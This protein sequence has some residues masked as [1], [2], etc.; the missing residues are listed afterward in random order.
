MKKFKTDKNIRKYVEAATNRFT[1]DVELWYRDEKGRKFKERIEGYCYTD[2]YFYITKDDYSKLNKEKGLIKS[3]ENNEID[4]LKLTS[5][6]FFEIEDNDKWVKV[7]ISNGNINEKYSKGKDDRLKFK[8]FLENR[9]IRIYEGDLQP[10]KR[11]CIDNDI[12]V[13]NNF[14]VLFFDIETDDRGHGILVGRDTILSIAGYD[15]D[16]KSYFWYKKH[17]Q[18]DDEDF[19]IKFMEDIRFKFDVLVGWNSDVFDKPYIIRRFQEHEINIWEFKKNIAHID[20][21]QIFI[22]RFSNNPELT[23]WK[24]DF[25]AYYFLGEK[26]IEVEKGNGKIYEL[27]LKDFEK[28]KK[29][30]LRD[31][32][33]LYELDNKLGVIQQ[34]LLECQITGCF[35]SKFSVSELL[36]TY[37]LRSTRDKNLHFPSIEY[38]DLSARCP[39]CNY[40]YIFEGDE[41]PFEHFC[42][43]CNTKFNP[44]NKHNDVA[45]AYVIEPATGRYDNVFVFDYKSLYPTIIDSWNIGPDSFIENEDYV[46]LEKYDMVGNECIKSANGQF[47]WKNKP[48]IFKIAIKELLSLRRKFKNKMLLC[49]PGTREYEILNAKQRATK[50]LSNSLYG[51]LAYPRGRFY[52]KEIAESITLGGQWLIKTTKKWFEEKGYHVLYG[53][54]VTGNTPV[55]IKQSEKVRL[56]YISELLST[57][58]NEG[59]LYCDTGKNKVETLSYNFK[60]DKYEWKDLLRVIKHKVSKQIKRIHQA[61]GCIEP[62]SDHGFYNSKRELTT[63][64]KFK[65]GERLNSENTFLGGIFEHRFTNLLKEINYKNQIIKVDENLGYVLGAY[66][67]EGSITSNTK[68][69]NITSTPI[70]VSIRNDVEYR[71]KVLNA[72]IKAFGEV[73]SHLKRLRV[74][75]SSKYYDFIKDS[76]GM[77]SH[78]KTI[79]KW[80]YETNIDFVK[81]LLFGYLRGDGY[82]KD[83]IEYGLVKGCFS[84]KSKILTAGIASLIL[85]LFPNSYYRFKYRHSK[86][87]YSFY[88]RPIENLDE[89]RPTRKLRMYDLDETDVYDLEVADN[90][91]F[92]DA[93]GNIVLHNTDSI[94]TLI[95]L[96]DKEKIPKLLEELKLFY[97]ESLKKN[98]NIDNHTIDLEYEKHF[99]RFIL[100]QKKRYAGHIIEQDDVTIDKILIKGL[101][102]VKRDTIPLG[103][104]WQKELLD[105]LINKNYN[106]GYYIKWVED[107]MKLFF[108]G[109][110][111]IS[112]IIITK[113]LSKNPKSYKV[114]AIHVEIA[115]E[116]KRR[117]FEYYI[118][119]RVPYIVTSDK[120]IEASHPSW[121]EKG[122]ASVI[123][124]WDKQ[125]FAI[126]Q[127]ILEAVF[128]EYDWSQYSSKIK[129]K[130]QKKIEQYKRWLKDPKKM[131]TFKSKEKT[132]AKI[133]ECKVISDEQREELLK[134]FKLKKFQ[135]I[136]SGELS[137]KPKIK[138][139]KLKIKNK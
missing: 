121:Y 21:M 34:I 32:W 29:Y 110:Y 76:C 118:G 74:T 103:R 71:D 88:W 108:G 129:N 16:G 115:E 112:D 66:L 125:I 18:S 116:L 82:Q 104:K 44:E 65:D 62:T 94:F 25:I 53:D 137:K 27:Y 33:L 10:H 97:N 24:L 26:K 131:K 50:L 28:F 92:I 57:E 42:K 5:A 70:L 30:N 43:F 87:A 64:K 68:R 52:R 56:V 93:L 47:Y 22:K 77:Y 113:K 48:S 69:G 55:Y 37:I 8:K 1:G 15:Q 58:L 11:Y 61:N 109:D 12:R 139:L 31:S 122:A 132:I 124:Y 45:G 38:G 2:W 83:L 72:A 86:E 67:A 95:P 106:K 80:I 79:P 81:G 19:L 17:S 78:G 134:P 84:S 41:L 96:E 23:S 136:E 117:E 40:N 75:C 85:S 51:I 99:R 133:K 138:I 73:F 114:R 6:P 101:E 105:L 35:P 130:R 46:E 123:Y 102:Y 60:T 49:K 111:D 127:R 20:L 59:I 119:M 3:L 107:K 128:K 13:S 36:D 91:N 89:K 63:F 120:P 90:H 39:Q 54:S 9:G 98:F 100:V 14:K 4:K 126:C 7:F 135:M